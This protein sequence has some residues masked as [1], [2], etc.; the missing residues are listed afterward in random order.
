MKRAVR[1]MLSDPPPAVDRRSFFKTL[2]LGTA[3]ALAL[4]G[5]AAADADAEF[6][7]VE[8]QARVGA[9]GAEDHR[10]ARGGGRRR[11]DDVPADPGRHQPG[12]R[13]LGRGPRRRERDIRADA[14]EPHPRREP[15][16]RRQDL[17]EDQA[18]R[19]G[20]A[21]GRRRVRR[22]DGD[23]G[24]GRQGLGRAVLA[25]ARRK[26]PRSGPA[27][28]R[29][30]RPSRSQGTGPDA[31]GAHGPGHHVPQAGFRNRVA[32]GRSRCALD[33]ARH[34]HRPG[35]PGDAPVHRDRDHRQG[36]RLAFRL[37]RPGP[38]GH[39]HGDSA[40]HRSL[41]PHQR[42][43]LHQARAGDGEMEPGVDGGHGAVAV[44]RADEADPGLD[45]RAHPH[46]ARTSS[47]RSPSSSSS[48]WA[49]ST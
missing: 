23:D 16:Q 32:A 17:P 38:R 21:A 49:P 2:G 5:E 31:Q 1:K 47:S 40:L 14:E 20:G 9:V 34:Q 12:A 19:R 33:A 45:D 3:G 11:A 27:L 28:R 22:R 43:Q 4:T 44:R 15:V 6:R 48:T 8:R 24:P 30:D 37:G 10:L 25:D 41:R 18:V 35:R 39:R 7:A 42:Q 36:R 46:R 13:R 26:V 29:Y